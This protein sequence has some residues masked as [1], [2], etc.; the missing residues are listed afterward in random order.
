MK[1]LIALPTFVGAFLRLA[2]LALVVSAVSTTA[3]AGEFFEKGGAALR[4][5]DPVAYF[6]DNKPVKG[7]AEH[8]AEYKGST[9][10][11]ASPANRDAFAA[12]P[13]KYAPQYGGFCAYGT[14]GGY[15]AAIDPAAF[16]IVDGK[17]YLNYNADV[18][19]QWSKDIPGYV[20]KADKN[21]PGV[22]KQTKVVE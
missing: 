17:L 12:D 1:R 4:G 14:A 9:F 10:Y 7:S 20:A 2:A 11:F 6:T 8:K 16:T 5:Y 3:S 21:W 18:Q 15:K 19:K 22:S 13:A